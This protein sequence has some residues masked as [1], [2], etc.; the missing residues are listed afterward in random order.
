MTKY[1]GGSLLEL[2]TVILIVAISIMITTPMLQHQVA[3]R[4]LETLARRLLRTPTLLVN[5]P[6]F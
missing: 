1:H 2:M 3:S 5:R 4:E 6:C